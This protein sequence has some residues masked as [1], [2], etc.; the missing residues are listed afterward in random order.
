LASLAESWQLGADAHV[1]SGEPDAVN[2][3]LDAY[4]VPRERD[5]LTGQVAHPALVY[6]LDANGTIAFASNGDAR[7]LRGLLAR[8]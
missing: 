5:E 4:Q 8:L 3:V 2:A 6:V 7:T 1:L